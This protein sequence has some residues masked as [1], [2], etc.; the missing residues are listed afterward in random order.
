MHTILKLNKIF[1]IRNCFVYL[2]FLSFLLL[3]TKIYTH[4]GVS[5]DEGLERAN[6]MVSLVYIGNY[7]N[8]AS[9]Q[10]DP[11]IAGYRDVRLEEWWARHYPVGFT[12]PA[13]LLEKFFHLQDEQQVFYFRHLLTFLVYFF[14]V[15]SVFKIAERRF[16]DWRIGLLA[17]TFLILSPRFFAESFYNSKDLVLMS[18]FAIVLN[19]MVAFVLK[20]TWSR[21]F[22]HAFT[23][24][25]AIDIR[26]MAI[27]FPLATSGLIMLRVAQR[28]LLLASAI[29]MI[30]SYFAFIII[31]VV[32]TWPYLWADPWGRFIEALTYM[33]KLNFPVQS[34][35]MGNIYAS[36]QLPWHYL[37]VWIGISTPPLYILFFIIGVISTIREVV[38]KGIEFFSSDQ[39]IQDGIF[40]I[41]F[42]AP[43]AAI[44]I[45]GSTMYDS[46]RHAYFIYPA[47][48]LLAVKGFTILKELKIRGRS[49][50]SVI[51][52]LTFACL[53]STGWWMKKNH[54]Y[55]NVYFN[56][57]AGHHWKDRFDLDYWGLSNRQALEYILDHDSREIIKV[58]ALNPVL[59]PLEMAK[60][61]IAPSQKTRIQVLGDISQRQQA[62]YI[63]TNYRLD[64]STPSEDA[65][66]LIHQIVVDKEVILSIFKRKI[67]K[68]IS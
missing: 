40:F 31:F 52:T 4:Y 7:L 11:Y 61:V 3:G 9:I 55:Q 46:W 64:S 30:L 50:G 60:T 2:F 63:I 22:L 57:L 13:I 16:D 34:L 62:D 35:Y 18:W 26:L 68:A 43:V 48:L 49:Y 51:T 23:S 1:S 27:V 29:V 59:M 32:I 65:F 14:G 39:M 10:N 19:S 45:L 54:P 47:F 6:G 21:L 20:P 58:Q 24:A 33:V 41:F 25:M 44:I 56:F 12:V 37:P 66:E 53:L 8:I 36:N 38:S 28:K 67:K 5:V 17:A 15:I 42:W